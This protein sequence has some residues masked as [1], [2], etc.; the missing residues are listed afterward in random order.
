MDIDL[1]A[2]AVTT[3]VAGIGSA[4][5]GLQEFADLNIVTELLGSDPTIGYAALGLGGVV[6]LTEQFEVTEFFDK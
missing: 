5:W 6:V 4:N 2:K 3:A 1:D